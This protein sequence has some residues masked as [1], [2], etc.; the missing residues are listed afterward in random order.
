MAKPKR[1]KISFY[2]LLQMFPDEQ[3]AEKFFENER[4]GVS[5]RYCPH[6]G[7]MRTVERKNRKPQPYR[8]KD[9][10]KDFSIKNGSVMWRSHIPLHKWLMAMYLLST[11]LK[12]VSS[13]KLGSDLGIKQEAA[14]LLA[15]KIRAAMEQGNGLFTNPVEADETYIG[16]LEKNKHADKKKHDGRGAKGKVAVLGVK[17]RES[18]KVAVKV[19]SDTT[20]KT[21]SSFIG[22]H[23]EAGNTVYTDEHKGYNP[24][25]VEYD[26]KS[27]KHSLGEYVDG[28]I[29]TNG[30]ESFWSMLKRG[31]IGTYH[32]LSEK[33]LQRYADEFAGRHNARQKPTID[34]I[35]EIA[36]GMRGKR[37][38]Y[39]ELVESGSPH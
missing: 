31:Y 29:H 4:W 7:S 20:G 9:C 34:Q 21:L 1:E 22:S 18:K 2:K 23:V 33:H 38:T 8:C 5:G 30:M 12:G 13:R 35:K 19:A 3:A 15:H 6:C 14:W 37:L 27:V 28:Q 16:G 10:R 25:A 17:E 36:G 24:I 39:K 26:R 11:S 32:R